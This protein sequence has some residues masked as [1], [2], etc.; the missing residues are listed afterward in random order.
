MS[1]YMTESKANAQFRLIPMLVNFS[2]LTVLYVAFTIC[3]TLV[4]QL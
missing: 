4:W 2:A 1:E 3:I